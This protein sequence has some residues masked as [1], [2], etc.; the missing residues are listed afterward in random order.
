M[1]NSLSINKIN[2]ED[3]QTILNEKSTLLINTL[4]TNKQNCLIKDTLTAGC[5]VETL[6]SYLKK[7]NSQIRIIIYGENSLDDSVITK[8]KQ[9]YSLGFS[10]IYI[11]AGGIFEWLLLQDI[12][13]SDLFPTTRIERDILQFKGKKKIGVR[14]IK[15]IDE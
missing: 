2:F 6:N 4:S 14:L 5:E 11:Y 1:G 15:D 7:G 12:Y 8:Y 13:G 9:L 10:N 3:I